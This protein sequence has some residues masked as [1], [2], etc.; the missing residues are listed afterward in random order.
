MATIIALANSAQNIL[1]KVRTSVDFLGPLLL[2][3]Y[4]VPVFFIAGQNK[5]N[6][7]AENSSLDST[8]RWF[9]NKEWGLGLPLPELMA[10]L[11]WGAEY[12]GAILLALGLATRWICIPLMVTMLVAATTVHWHNGWQ[13][14]YDLQSPWPPAHAEAALDRLM[15]AKSL[16]QEHGNYDWLS[17]YGSFVMSNNGI[18]WAS[19]YFVMLLALFF[20]G[21]GKYISADYWIK[22]KFGAAN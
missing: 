19:T 16:L 1:D 8:I 12:I 2:R 11:A 17:E 3:L 4:L 9:G 20:L 15:R 5:W 14:I 13:A 6:P 18:E 22:R 7:F 21:G 10:Y